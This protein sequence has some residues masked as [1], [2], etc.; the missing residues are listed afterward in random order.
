MKDN[1]VDKIIVILI[2]LAVI[3]LIAIAEILSFVFIS[4]NNNCSNVRYCAMAACE[5]NSCSRDGDN[6]ICTNCKASSVLEDGADWVGTCTFQYVE[7][8]D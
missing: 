7:E 6:V 2:V 4:N 3:Q 5:E 1:K 8:D